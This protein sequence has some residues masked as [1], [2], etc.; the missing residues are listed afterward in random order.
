MHAHRLRVYGSISR[1]EMSGERGAER[2]PESQSYPA[3]LY[4]ARV[5]GVCAEDQQQAQ[6]RPQQRV[7]RCGYGAHCMSTAAIAPCTLY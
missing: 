4:Q 1:C 5:A 3:P 6:R 2:Q 7:G